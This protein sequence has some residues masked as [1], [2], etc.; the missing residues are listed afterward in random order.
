VAYH[1]P[2]GTLSFLISVSHLETAFD[3]IPNAVSQFTAYHI[4]ECTVSMEHI[5][6]LQ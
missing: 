3:I 6:K 5:A 2:T 1:S 4:V